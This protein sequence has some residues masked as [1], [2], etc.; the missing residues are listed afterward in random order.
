ME[1]YQQ[2]FR[3]T[4]IIYFSKNAL[5]KSFLANGVVTCVVV[6]KCEWNVNKCSA[7]FCVV[8]FDPVVHGVSS[9]TT[10]ETNDDCCR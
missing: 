9:G 7:V 1:I 6:M 5:F 10:E 8:E 3:C 4:K 2:S